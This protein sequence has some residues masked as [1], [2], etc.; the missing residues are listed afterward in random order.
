MNRLGFA[1]GMAFG[2]FIDAARMSD[3]G[4]IHKALLFQSAYM[5]LMMGSAVA[6]AMPLLLFLKRKSWT[7]PLGGP[8]SIK[9][10]KIERK[11]IY[12]GM[13]FG[14]GWAVACTCPAPALTML[15][16]GGV[17]GLFVVAGL[18]F[19]LRLRDVVTER[20]QER[21]VAPARSPEPSHLPAGAVADL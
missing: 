7:T 3:P 8:L 14:T 12:G 17:L 15:G 9:P 21:A 6:V 2:F 16:S 10:A 1:F 19:G 18:F 11:H 13:V 20:S 5:F 4:I